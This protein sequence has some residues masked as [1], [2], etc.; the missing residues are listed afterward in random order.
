M[1]RLKRPSILVKVASTLIA[2][3]LTFGTALLTTSHLTKHLTGMSKAIEQAG[4]ERVRIHKLGSIIQGDKQ[5]SEHQRELIRTQMG[6]FE[7]VMDGWRF[8]TPQ[9]ASVSEMSPALSAQLQ[10]VQARW[11]IRLQP[12]LERALAL[13]SHGGAARHY[14]EQADDF[15]AGLDRLVQSLESI[16][17]RGSVFY[18]RLPVH[19]REPLGSHF[20][21][22]PA[23][24]SAIIGPTVDRRLQPTEHT[25]PAA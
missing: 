10:S 18:L 17:G 16:P 1:S 3:S 5:W 11:S 9:H 8:G 6:E 4:T 15:V 22:S 21:D 24:A 19:S 20:T 25:E 23:A 14:L 2:V 7:R 13:Q 12:T